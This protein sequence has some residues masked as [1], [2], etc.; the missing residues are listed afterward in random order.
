MWSNMATGDPWNKG[1]FIGGVDILG[2]Y[3][4]NVARVNGL[5]LQHHEDKEVARCGYWRLDEE[6]H[7]LRSITLTV[8][9]PYLLSFYHRTENLADG[10]ATVWVSYDPM[11]LFAHD[12]GLPGTHGA[13]RRFVAVGWNR[14]DAEAAISPL[15]RSFATGSVAFDN[16]QVRPVG[17]PNDAA[18]EVGETRS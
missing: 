4:G 12:H 14:S 13:W 3:S 16:V 15:V 6:Q 17:L 2:A 5:W 9:S 1:A 18:V 8:G 10:A 11:V 7:D